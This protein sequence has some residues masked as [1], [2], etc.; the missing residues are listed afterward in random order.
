[1]GAPGTAAKAVGDGVIARWAGGIVWDGVTTNRAGGVVPD[2]VAVAVLVAAGE[3]VSGGGTM[4]PVAS[5]VTVG[6][7]TTNGGVAVGLGVCCLRQL[8]AIREDSKILSTIS[9]QS[10]NLMVLL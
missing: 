3:V 9:R 5:C 4:M 7:L 10:H 8:M 6:S 1:V 2:S